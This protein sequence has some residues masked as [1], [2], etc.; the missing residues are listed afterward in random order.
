MI[1]TNKAMDTSITNQ[2]NKSWDEIEKVN[3][4][5]AEIIENTFRIKE[6][7]I[8][9]E[10]DIKEN[11]NYEKIIETYKERTNY[12]IACNEIIYEKNRCTPKL[13]EILGERLNQELA[14]KYNVKFVIYI[15][16]QELNNFF[17][18]RFHIDRTNDGEN[19]WLDEDID[20]YD[21]PIMMIY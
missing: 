6:C 3:R 20:K 8:Y 1:K 9:S 10:G 15:S 21:E 13:Y 14:K 7:V 19:L 16:E 5:I 18:I 4:I 17:E 12:E 2:T 11:I